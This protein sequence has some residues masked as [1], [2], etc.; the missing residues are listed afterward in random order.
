MKTLETSIVGSKTCDNGYPGMI[1]DSMFCVGKHESC[2][3]VMGAP[4]VCDGALQGIFIY[5]FTTTPNC[6]Q[7]KENGLGVVSKICIAKSW[8]LQ[9]M[10]S[11]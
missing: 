10:S 9:T 5:G 4:I 7:Q 6:G 8:L 3:I 1:T 11:Y 2:K